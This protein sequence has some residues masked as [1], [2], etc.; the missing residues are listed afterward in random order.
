[1]SNSCNF[2]VLRAL[3]NM[4]VGS[5]EANFNIIDNEVQ[6]DVIT[7]FP[8]INSSSLKGGLKQHFLNIYNE[9]RDDKED[10]KNKYID[11]TFGSDNNIGHYNFLNANLLSIPVRSNKKQFFRATC[12][13]IINDLLSSLEDFNYNKDIIIES[14]N[15]LLKINA[16]RNKPVILTEKGQ[17]FDENIKIETMDTE[18]KYVDNFDTY[19][20]IF[21]NDIVLY[22]DDDFNILTKNLPVIARNHLDNGESKNLW[23]EEIV[24]RESRFYFIILQAGD[25]IYEFNKILIER[26]VQIGANATIGYGFSI[27]EQL[28]I[29]NE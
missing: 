19:E 9:K 26:P 23:Y 7:N 5:G 4:H 2:F 16:Y 27:I 15:S 13:R 6:R 25:N 14:L 28:V 1:M 21:G 12:P 3:T 29:E 22:S 24:P 18:L 10:F 8:V 17:K 11:Y 20:R